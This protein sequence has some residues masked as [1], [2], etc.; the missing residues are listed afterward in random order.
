MIK[1]VSGSRCVLPVI[2]EMPPCWCPLEIERPSGA[3][4]QTGP[5]SSKYSPMPPRRAVISSHSIP[6]SPWRALIRGSSTQLSDFSKIPLR[7]PLPVRLHANSSRWGWQTKTPTISLEP[8][9]EMGRPSLL[10]VHVRGDSVRLSGRC[11]KVADG[12][13]LVR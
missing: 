6:Y 11:V 2:L 10:R 5:S 4:I 13:L 8:G 9:Y 3:R 1:K 7:E 12:A